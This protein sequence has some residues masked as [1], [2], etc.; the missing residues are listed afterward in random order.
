MGVRRAGFHCKSKKAVKEVPLVA[1]HRPKSM[2]DY[3]VHAQLRT[4][5]MEDKPKGTVKCGNRRCQ[6]CEHL[7]TGDSFTSKRTGH[8]PSNFFV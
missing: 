1:F 6:V 2:E 7:K 5:S 4:T 8:V 3:L